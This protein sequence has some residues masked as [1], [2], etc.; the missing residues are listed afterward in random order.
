MHL[1]LSLKNLEMRVSE[2]AQQVEEPTATLDDSV[3]EPGSTWWEERTDVFTLV[4]GLRLTRA[5]T[6]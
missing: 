5:Y 1:L 4:S 3:L 6:K 2:I